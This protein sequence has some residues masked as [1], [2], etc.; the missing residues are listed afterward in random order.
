MDSITF[1][2]PLSMAGMGACILISLAAV[3]VAFLFGRKKLGARVSS[4]FVGI[5]TFTLFAVLFIFTGVQMAGIGVIGEYIGRIYTDV[6]ARPRYFIEELLGR[7]K[8]EEA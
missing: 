6:R 4:F 3:V 2:P 1:V 8:K 5:G 7:A